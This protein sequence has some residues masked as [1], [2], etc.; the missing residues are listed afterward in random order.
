[1]TNENE[2]R[3][4]AR[5]VLAIAAGITALAGAIAVPVAVGD[6]VA[7][8]QTTARIEACV[9]V[10]NATAAITCVESVTGHVPYGIGGNH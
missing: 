4:W 8:Q 10:S 9:K 1:M 7:A 5:I 2:L 6:H 3:A